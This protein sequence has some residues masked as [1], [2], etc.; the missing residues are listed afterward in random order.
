M[1]GRLL[2][3]AIEHHV[4]SWKQL[5]HPCL[6]SSHLAALFVLA[7]L[8]AFKVR[9]D[10]EVDG[11]KLLACMWILGKSFQWPSTCIVCAK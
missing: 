2:R 9:P 7:C 11:P 8:K 1:Q 6:L 4:P 10:D 3:V 5:K